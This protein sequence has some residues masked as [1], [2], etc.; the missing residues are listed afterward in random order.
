LIESR[1]LHVLVV[2]QLEIAILI[3]ISNV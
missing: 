3:M 2:L 1:I